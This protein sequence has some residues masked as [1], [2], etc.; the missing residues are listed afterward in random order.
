VAAAVQQPPPETPPPTAGRRNLRSVVASIAAVV[1]SPIQLIA[2]ASPFSQSVAASTV[3]EQT[4]SPADAAN[5]A[6][7]TPTPTENTPIN[8]DEDDDEAILRLA[9]EDYN[10]KGDGG[11]SDDEGDEINE[12]NESFL[13][14]QEERRDNDDR[15]DIDVHEEGEEFVRDVLPGAPDGWSPPKADPTYTYIRQFDAPEFPDN[16]ANWSPFAFQPKYKNGKYLGHFTP[17]GAKVVPADAN[18]D[19]IVDEWKFCYTDFELDDFG[20]DCYVRGTA[21]KWFIFLIKLMT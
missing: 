15:E 7:T 13:E 14:R 4:A 18:G 9:E 12:H 2:G 16:P 19:R 5:E 6:D 1:A 21:T 11:D 20:R 17:G 3:T 8:D 10:A